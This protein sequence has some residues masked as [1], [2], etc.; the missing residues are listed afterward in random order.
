MVAIG[1]KISKNLIKSS[2]MLYLFLAFAALSVATNAETIP[3]HLREQL[4]KASSFLEIAESFEILYHP[5]HTNRHLQKSYSTIG[6]QQP[7]RI[8]AANFLQSSAARRKSFAVQEATTTSESMDMDTAEHLSLFRSIKQGNDTCQLQSVCVPI[9]LDNGDPQVVEMLYV[10]NGR[11]M[12][13][14]TLNIS[15]EEHTSCS[16]YDCGPNVPECPPGFVI[17]SDCKCQC[18]NRSDRHNCEG[19]CCNE[20]SD[21]TSTSPAQPPTRH[22]PQHS[23]AFSKFKQKFGI[24]VFDRVLIFALLCDFEVS[25]RPVTDISPTVDLSSLPKL[26]ARVVHHNH[27]V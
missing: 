27:G 4:K 1:W 3:R 15:M 14:Q 26:K 18:A 8:K 12:L 6:P 21:F 19:E 13:N 17:G 23:A 10:G 24:K 25:V 9:P 5:L 22:F 16:C 2:I 20:P 11:F 7:M